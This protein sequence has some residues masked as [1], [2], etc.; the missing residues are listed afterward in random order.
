MKWERL[1]STGI[2]RIYRC[3]MPGGWLIALKLEDGAGDVLSRPE[4]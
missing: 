2:N 4:P 1:E 3:N